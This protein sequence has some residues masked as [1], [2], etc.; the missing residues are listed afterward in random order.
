MKRAALFSAAVAVVSIGLVGLA[1]AADKKL[2]VYTSMKESLIGTL[3]NSFVKKHPDVAMDYQSAGAGKLMAKIAA[4]RESGK[5]LADVLWTSEVPD[6]YQ[7]KKE[8]LLLPYVSPAVKEVMNPLPDYDGSFTAVRLGTLGIAFNTRFVKE[9][10]KT[11]A[12]LEKAA[13]KNGFGI[14]NPAL[15]GT[16]Y[17]SVALLSKQFGWE[18]FQKL[19][20]NRAKMG[21]GSGQVV[22]DTASGDLLGSLAVD[23]ITIDKM[24]KGATIK[25]VFPPEMLV[26]PS[27]ITIFKGTPN[28]EAAKAFIDFVL[29]KEGQAIIA[30]EGTLPVR[31][32][33]PVMEKF[34]L[35]TVED[36]MKRAIKVDYPQ[37]IA[38]KEA[39]IK[40]FTEIFQK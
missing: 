25:I 13:F 21:Q 1:E 2:F 40:K 11:W 3:K 33:V 19:R 4:E 32:G 14:A 36:A 5:I 28:E 30:S 26:I 7:L 10:P 8:G 23:Y 15:S 12:D 6:F 39:T 34:G 37:L 16:A 9:P 24:E 31:T 29:S 35:P 27:P 20:A 18:F 38:D 22:D 17:M